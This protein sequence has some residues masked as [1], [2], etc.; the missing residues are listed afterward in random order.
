MLKIK[1]NVDLKELEKFGWEY[2]EDDYFLGNTKYPHWFKL[3]DYYNELRIE[4]ENRIIIGTHDETLN[5]ASAKI[6]EYGWVDDLIKAG[7]IEKVSD[8]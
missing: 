7:L 2:S 1:D 3:F 5:I 6:L 4:P 8:E